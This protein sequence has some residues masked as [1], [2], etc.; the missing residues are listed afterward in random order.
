MTNHLIFYDSLIKLTYVSIITK[1]NNHFVSANLF[2]KNQK[3]K[4]VCN[5]SR[6]TNVKYTHI[7]CRHFKFCSALMDGWDPCLKTPTRQ[8]LVLCSAMLALTCLLQVLLLLPHYLLFS[9]IRLNY[10][11]RT[12]SKYKKLFFFVLQPISCSPDTTTNSETVRSN[13]TRIFVEFSQF[14]FV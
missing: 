6:V 4:C 5:D 11:W 3:S 14:L 7:F 2:G 12:N 9:R 8:I 10:L 1:K 13:C